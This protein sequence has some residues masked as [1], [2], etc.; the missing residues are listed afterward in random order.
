V[1]YRAW[2]YPDALRLDLGE[3]LKLVE[4]FETG[5]TYVVY[6]EIG[7]KSAHLAWRMRAAGL[8][9]YNFHGGL[10]SLVHYAVAHGLVA[11]ELLPDGMKLEN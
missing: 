1:A 6:C 2:H 5:K 9:A 4:R 8:D 7:L 3:A 11:R 10:K